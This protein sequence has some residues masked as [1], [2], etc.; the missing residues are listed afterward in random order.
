MLYNQIRFDNKFFGLDS[1]KKESQM[2]WIRINTK[3]RETLPYSIVRTELELQDEY[4]NLDEI[5]KIENSSVFSIKE[6]P[7]RPYNFDDDVV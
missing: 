4:I 7:S 5:T 1:I 2:A 6:L 3:V